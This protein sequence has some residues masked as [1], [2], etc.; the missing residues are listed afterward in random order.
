M[1]VQE[2]YPLKHLNTFGMD[3]YAR[4]FVDIT[5]RDVLPEIFNTPCT[6]AKP[7]IVLGGGSNV[8]FRGD[9]DGTLLHVGLRGKQ[10]L[11]ENKKNVWLEA[12][13]GEPWDELVA[14]CVEN[15][16]GGLENLSLI[17]GQA[18]SSPIQ[19]IGAYGVELKDHFYSLEA[20]CKETGEVKTFNREDCRFAYRHSFF[21]EEGKGKF[22]ILSVTFCLDKNPVI[23]TDYGGLKRELESMGCSNPDIADVRS[24]V[25]RI[26]ESKLP[27][28]EITGNAG[29]FFKNPVVPEKIYFQL[30][31]THPGIVA[32]PESNGM[33]LAAGWLIDQAGWKGY[34]DG[35]A[36]VHPKQ[37]LVLINHGKATGTDILNL[38]SR[39]QDSVKK[40]FGVTLE[41]EVNI[42]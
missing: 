37:A 20:W 10:I 33:K 17:P 12:A 41:P 7:H 40:H 26:R 35:D 2:N 25:C 18:G 16:W 9:Y 22:I 39:I 5:F 15:G 24:A 28:P 31:E 19:N 29:S 6:T 14:F 32:Y 30:M 34:R 21:K 4:Y 23:R 8:L 1:L 3:V 13:A 11:A 38:A 27:D 42:V 36:G